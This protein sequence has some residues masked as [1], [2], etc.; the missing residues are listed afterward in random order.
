M[1]ER[2]TP[3]LTRREGIFTQPIR[4]ADGREW[5]IA[6]PT[7]TLMPRV[8][9][10]TDEF[11]RQSEL[12][13]VD[14]GFGYPSEIEALCRSVQAASASGPVQEQYTAFFSLAAAVLRRAHDISLEAALQLLEVSGDELPALVRTITASALRREPIVPPGACGDLSR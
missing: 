7:V 5:G 6:L 10:S 14:V 1:S 12:V 2:L 9:V 11:G 4:L 13:S 3:E 8:V